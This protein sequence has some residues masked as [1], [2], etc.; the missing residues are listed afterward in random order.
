MAAYA[1]TMA[2]YACRMAVNIVEGYVI[3]MSK[4]WCPQ[5]AR[6]GF[7]TPDKYCM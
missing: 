7:A 2:A 5:Y 3:D 1:Y 6:K 4:P